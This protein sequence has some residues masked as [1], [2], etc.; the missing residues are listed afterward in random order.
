MGDS[1]G[2]GYLGLGGTV[3]LGLEGDTGLLHMYRVC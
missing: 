1:I 2:E 3:N